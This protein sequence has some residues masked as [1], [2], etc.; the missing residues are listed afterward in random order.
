M[1]LFDCSEDFS[2]YLLMPSIRSQAKLYDRTTPMN[3]PIPIALLK[4]LWRANDPFA[5]CLPL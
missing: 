5:A 1:S 3:A 2:R 4:A